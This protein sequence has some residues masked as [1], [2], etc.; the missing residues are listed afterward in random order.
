MKIICSHDQNGFH[1]FYHTTDVSVGTYD[2][3][4]HTNAFFEVTYSEPFTNAAKILLNLPCKKLKRHAKKLYIY[5]YKEQIHTH[6]HS[7]IYYCI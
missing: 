3:K 2:W 4:M 6:R 1:R 5:I 7:S